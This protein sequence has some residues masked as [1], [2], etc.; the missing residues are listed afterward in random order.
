M[1]H[2]PFADV[3][4]R[5]KLSHHELNTCEQAS[6]EKKED[7]LKTFRQEQNKGFVEDKITLDANVSQLW[8]RSQE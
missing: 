1:E 4:A 7:Q 8:E 5:L 3:I 2:I 6:D